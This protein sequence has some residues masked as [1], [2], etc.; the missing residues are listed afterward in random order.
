MS[1]ERAMVAGVRSHA[2]AARATDIIRSEAC[3][4]CELAIAPQPVVLEPPYTP[5][6]LLEGAPAA[7]DDLGWAYDPHGHASQRLRFQ[8]W[9]S[10][11]QHCD[12]R[13]AELFLKQ[14]SLLQ[15]HVAFEIVG[16]CSLVQTYVV[17]SEQDAS[18]VQ[19]AFRGQFEQCLLSSTRSG[20]FND[21]P[22]RG[23]I[24]RFHDYAPTPPYSHLLTRPDQ[25]RRSP[26]VSLLTTLTLLPED[27]LGFYQVLFVPVSPQHDWHANV[28][29]LQDLEYSTKLLS[30][31]TDARHFLQQAPSGA[32]TQ[33]AMELDNKAAND[34]PF[35][36][37]AW[38]IGVCGGELELDAAHLHL[39]E[40]VEHVAL[41]SSGSRGLRG[42]RYHPE[43]THQP[44]R[45]TSRFRRHRVPPSNSVVLSRRRRAPGAAHNC[46]SREQHHVG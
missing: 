4:G 13:R 43:H 15:E 37:V 40:F 45:Q 41:G 33:M 19:A 28:R 24:T 25:L 39:L 11:Q 10:P 18:L 22:P 44:K 6:S 26:L 27:S 14:L 35:Y 20:P 31:L 42:K 23:G 12:W 3:K 36:A 17:C 5:I 8:M 38:R 34:K 7:S 2:L 9:V 21:G 32:L 1:I 46:D 16:N 30:G 29:V